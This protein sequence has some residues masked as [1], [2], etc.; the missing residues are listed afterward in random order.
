MGFSAAFTPR[1]VINSVNARANANNKKLSPREQEF[2]TLS[3][4]VTEAPTP[5]FRTKACQNIPEM[6]RQKGVVI[7]K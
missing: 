4:H 5:I 2:Y 7:A 6:L 1:S 3:P